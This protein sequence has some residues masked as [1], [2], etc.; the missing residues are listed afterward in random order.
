MAT[1]PPAVFDHISFRITNPAIAELLA[2]RAE[3]TGVSPS[4]IAR[5][6]FTEAL[7]REDELASQLDQ[8]QQKVNE[9]ALRMHKL[10]ALKSSLQ[11]GLYLVLRHGGKLDARQATAEVERCFAPSASRREGTANVDREKN[12]V[13]K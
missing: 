12:G 9:L 7:T 6:L 13:R 11:R 10:N 2:E 4:L 3:A 1:K 8:I 5:Q